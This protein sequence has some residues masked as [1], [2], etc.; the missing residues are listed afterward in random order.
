MMKRFNVF[1]FASGCV[2]TSLVA[3]LAPGLR[4]Q[5]ENVINVCVEPDGIMR[6]VDSPQCPPGQERLFFKKPDV[7]VSKPDDQNGSP[8]NQ[9]S[10]LKVRI[11]ELERQL[12]NLEDAALNGELGNRV[13]APFSVVDR[14]GKILFR[15]DNA[16]GVVIAE[17]FNAAGESV[18]RMLG[19]ASG[20]RLSARSGN[21][22]GLTTHLGISDGGQ[23]AG[24][25]VLEN[26]EP[27]VT[28]GRDPA[29]GIYRL[30][31]LGKGQKVL[32]SI[33]QNSQ[34][35]GL[36]LVSDEQGQPRALLAASG[37]KG[38]MAA[39][40]APGTQLTIAAL[41]QGDAGGGAMRIWGSSGG[42]PLVEAGVDKNGV[43]VVRAGP[44]GFKPGMGVLGLPGSS[45]SGK[46]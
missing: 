24:L 26:G 13:V 5:S 39:V 33:G 20:G 41:M 35:N 27:R 14:A 12:K 21:A 25:E 3:W 2:A 44:D 28:L 4:A 29:L 38:G 19:S 6:V 17:V 9:A 22:N 36:A 45:I 16:D 15:V 10:M 8:D 7:E 23:T 43:G 37:D 11:A 34:G 40:Y 1:A 30:R 32:A 46:R 31:V 42:E 18:A